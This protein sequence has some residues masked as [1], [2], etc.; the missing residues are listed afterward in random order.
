MFKLHVTLPLVGGCKV[1]ITGSNF[2]ENRVL[3]RMF[4]SEREEDG[5]WRKLHIHEACGDDAMR[6]SAVFK[7]WKCF[8]DGEMNV[9]EQN[10]LFHYPPEACGKRSAARFREVG[11][12]L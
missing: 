11:G 3:M 2:F 6:R 4:G 5:S 10:R 12:A 8:R 1:E 9:K 7:W